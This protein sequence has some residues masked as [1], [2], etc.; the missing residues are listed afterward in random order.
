MNMTGA[1]REYPRSFT[2]LVIDRLYI[3]TDRIL[4]AHAPSIGCGE[5]VPAYSSKLGTN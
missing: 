4:T 5:A 1:E 2:M 3:P